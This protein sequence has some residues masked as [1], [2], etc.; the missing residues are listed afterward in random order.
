MASQRTSQQQWG[1]YYPSPHPQH[2]LDLEDEDAK[3]SYDDL[4]DQ[5]AIPYH[6][7]SNHKPFN[8][9]SSAFRTADRSNTAVG[10]PLSQKNTGTM[11]SDNKDFEGSTVDGHTW[12]Y[13]PPPI[14]EETPKAA[15]WRVVRFL[16]HRF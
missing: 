10:Y 5:Y 1:P 3:A 6:Q 4:I 2:R 7:N 15:W 11:E 13:P 8:V 9:D 14:K 16:L 12:A